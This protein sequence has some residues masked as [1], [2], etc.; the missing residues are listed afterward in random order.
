MMKKLSTV[1]IIFSFVLFFTGCDPHQFRYNR[2]QL[3]ENTVKITL[4]AYDN[5]SA[6]AIDD[7]LAQAKHRDFDFTN[8]QFQ[9]TLR[10]EKYQ[11]FFTLL[12]QADIYDFSK[13]KDSP[14][15]QCLLITYENGDFDVVAR[16]YIGR[17]NADG[18]FLTYFGIFDSSLY[19]NRFQQIIDDSDGSYFETDSTMT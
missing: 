3:E 15:G 11:E 9:K 10:P 13:H 8:A 2:Q 6:H 17:Y 5:P 1:I 4:I 12:V 18:K 14:D 7:T 16:Q 19:E